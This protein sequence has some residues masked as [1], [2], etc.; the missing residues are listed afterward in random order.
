MAE[1]SEFSE[2]DVSCG[3]SPEKSLRVGRIKAALTLAVITP[4]LTELFSANM[5]PWEVLN[6]VGLFLQLMAYGVPVLFIREVAVRRGAG[7]PGLFLMGL[8]YSLYNEG[9]IAKTLFLGPPGGGMENY[10]GFT[11]FG[12]HLFWTVLI[13]TWHALHAIVFPIALVSALFG[14][15]RSQSWVSLP[16]MAALAA[17]W[18]PLSIIGFLKLRS[19]YAHWGYFA[20]FVT[21]ITVLLMLGK[22]LPRRT[23]FFTE[24]RGGNLRQV[25]VGMVFYPV[26]IIGYF[27]ATNFGAPPAILIFWPYG[28]VTAVYF[29]LRAKGWAI[30]VPIAFIALG[31][32]GF[33]SLVNMLVHLDQEPLAKDKV[34]TL[35]LLFGSLAF[36]TGMVLGR[37]RR[38]EPSSPSHREKKA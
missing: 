29:F 34:V 32:Y 11:L 28:W 35:V 37:C 19:E 26:V 8:A 22:C 7:L 3:I 24:G 33:G 31:D 10:D 9:I 16:V 36:I 5:G 4:I 21:A 15:V 38:E 12:I 2:I 27:L 13:T 14:R 23:A 20:G 17:V 30:C 6:P 25:I 1:G 18:A